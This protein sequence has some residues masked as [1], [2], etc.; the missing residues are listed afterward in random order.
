MTDDA[1][2]LAD[3]VVRAIYRKQPVVEDRPARRGSLVRVV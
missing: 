2:R 3:A 1:I